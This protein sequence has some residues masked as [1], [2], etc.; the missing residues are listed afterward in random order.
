M[1]QLGNKVS[2]LLNFRNDL[3]PICLCP[4]FNS[5]AQ[6]FPATFQRPGP[7][8]SHQP[9]EL[10]LGEAHVFGGGAVVVVQAGV[11]DQRVVGVQGVVGLVLPEP[12]G[13]TR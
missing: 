6:S 13:R 11:E 12:E 5:A 9:F 4:C 3:P 2:I 10:F 1:H 8:G 7:R